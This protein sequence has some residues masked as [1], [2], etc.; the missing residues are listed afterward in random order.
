MPQDKRFDLALDP[1]ADVPGA[2]LL[3]IDDPS[4]P[5]P[6]DPKPGKSLRDL[7][8]SVGHLD[9]AAAAARS[10]NLIVDLQG[11]IDSPAADAAR[12]GHPP[13]F[14][15]ADDIDNYLWE[16]DRRIAA[17]RRHE[18][19]ASSEP[20][21][22]TLAPHALAAAGGA[23]GVAN[24]LPHGGGH[25]HHHHHHHG[26][27][28]GP[29]AGRDFA[30]RNPTSVYNWLRKHEPKVFLQDGEGGDKGGGENGEDGGHHGTGRGRR[31]GGGERGGGRGAGGGAGSRSSKRAS[32]AHA[33][34][35]VHSVVDHDGGDL[36]DD[37]T[38]GGGGGGHEG[39]RGAGAGGGASKRKRPVDDDPGYRPKGGSSRPAKK[40]RKSE[41]GGGDSTPTAATHRRP[42]KSDAGA[43]HAA[44]AGEAGEAGGRED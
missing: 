35:R 10:P 26:K 33:R 31:G 37:T 39:G 36:D 44:P 3:E 17:Q 15:T 34:D 29:G 27:D 6:G 28:G 5:K 1:P 13:S 8:T 23:N 2:V 43:A 19:R 7:V 24:G 18:G 14:L 9:Y 4:K 32:A 21:V 40:K 41:G 38:A 25:H 22:P 20:P 11:G 42:R 12:A 30:L 16:T